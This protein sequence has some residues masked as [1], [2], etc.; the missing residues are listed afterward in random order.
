MLNR[1]WMPGGIEA[2]GDHKHDDEITSAPPPLDKDPYTL[3]DTVDH[4]AIHEQ[5]VVP[6]CPP[7]SPP[8]TP[9]SAASSAE[10]GFMNDDDDVGQIE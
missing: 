6:D 5:D 9:T 3:F 8:Y 4:E 1:F 2:S 7:D 10:S